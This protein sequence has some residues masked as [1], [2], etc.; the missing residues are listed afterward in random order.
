MT[1]AQITDDT[2]KQYISRS[3]LEKLPEWFGIPES[4]EEYIKESASK[5]FFA[6]TAEKSRWAFYA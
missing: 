3:I 2:E 5:V 4:R 1:I 6:P